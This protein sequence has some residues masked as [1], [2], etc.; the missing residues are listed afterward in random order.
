L[1]NLLRQFNDQSTQLLKRTTKSFLPTAVYLT[2]RQVI[3]AINNAN[4]FSRRAVPSKAAD[5]TRE[6][7]ERLQEVVIDWY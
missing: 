4:P 1:P 7:L 5:S 3:N 6:D 2:A